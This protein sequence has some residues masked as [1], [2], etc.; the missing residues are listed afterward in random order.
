MNRTNQRIHKSLVKGVYDISNAKAEHIT[1]NK[2]KNQGTMVS[3]KENH[4]TLATKLKGIEYCCIT[5]KK[6]KIAIMN[7]LSEL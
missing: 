6:F 3:Q 2:K 4:Y 7:K 1:T 5:D